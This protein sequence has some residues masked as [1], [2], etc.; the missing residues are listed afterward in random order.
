ME[1]LVPVD[2][3]GLT[4]RYKYHFISWLYVHSWLNELSFSVYKNRK[5]SDWGARASGIIHDPNKLTK[6]L[7]DELFEAANI[8]GGGKAFMSFQRSEI[9]STKVRTDFTP[10]LHEIAVPTLFIQGENDT[11]VPMDAVKRAAGLVPG[12]ELHIMAGCGHWANREA[13][14]EFLDT[15]REFLFALIHYKKITSRCPP[16]AVAAMAYLKSGSASILSI[17][18]CHT[19]SGCQIRRKG[20]KACSSGCFRRMAL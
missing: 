15:V 18:A 19:T 1:R 14:D 6:E 16:G 7:L 10:R 3:Y 17:K 12:A 5:V 9:K 8:P 11:A 2:A 4:N 20:A 13:P